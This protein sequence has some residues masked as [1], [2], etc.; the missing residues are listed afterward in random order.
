MIE[1]VGVE[2]GTRYLWIVT[3]SGATNCRSCRIAVLT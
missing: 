3:E 2:G 1:W